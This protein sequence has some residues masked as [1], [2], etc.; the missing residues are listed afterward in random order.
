MKS[1]R[2][3]KS[4]DRCRRETASLRRRIAGFEKAKISRRKAEEELQK[5][6][7]EKEL[8]LSAISELV[9]YQDKK[10]RIIWANKAAADSAGATAG[11]LGGRHCYEIWQQREVPCPECPV[12]ATIK[13]GEPRQGELESPDGRVWFI[14]SY[15]V[16]GQDGTAIGAVE[17]TQEVTARERAEEALRESEERYRALFDRSLL[18]V[19]VHDLSGRFLDANQAALNMLGYDKNELRSL[20]FASILDQSQLPKA[21]RILDETVRTGSQ[22]QP[23]EFLLRRK[24]GTHVW[25]ETEASVIMRE[26]ISLAVQGIAR[27]I[28]DRK[29]AEEELKA[30]LQEKEALL[31]EIHHRVKNNLQ[32][33]SSLLDMRAMRTDDQK[34]AELCRDAQAEIQTMSL[35]HTHI[36]QSGRFSQ[37]AMDD[38][39]QDLVRYLSQVYFEKRDRLTPI[40]EQTDICLSVG[41]AVPLAIILNEA[42]SNTYKHA[43]KEEQRGNLVISLKRTGP[44]MIR[45][46]VKDDG[47][48][49]PPEL[50]FY[51]ADTLGL[52]LI[53]NLVKDQ[54]KGSIRVI[55]DRGTELVVEFR[56]LTEEEED[57]GKNI[58]RG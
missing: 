38:Y 14:R 55:Q 31:R 51:R 44:G 32:V 15:P 45:L 33:I 48:G 9:N 3:G 29:K 21:F 54:L 37:I 28:T 42:I 27:D 23:E 18:C 2:A 24:D 10:H 13:S 20:T 6:E 40:I 19:Y 34:M 50:D 43:F 39:L 17:V 53:R 5:S 30:S 57:N 7:H 16:R 26:K 1:K 4:G 8:I 35:I 47:I 58:D 41:Q 56:A 52:K 46:S 22:K 36:Y 25:V 12:A 49:L 11:Q